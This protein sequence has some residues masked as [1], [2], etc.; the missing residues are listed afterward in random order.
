MLRS[1]SYS[2]V[3]ATS[4]QLIDCFGKVA[5]FTDVDHVKN[6]PFK[7]VLLSQCLLEKPWRFQDVLCDS[8]STSVLV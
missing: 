1:V 5:A 6:T 7:N 3:L 2:P 4:L 8:I